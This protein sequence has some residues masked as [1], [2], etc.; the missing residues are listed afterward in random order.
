MANEQ[1][2]PPTRKEFARLRQRIADLEERLDEVESSSS[3]KTG[4]SGPG[5]HRDN[6]V[7]EQL[8]EGK[9]YRLNQVARLYREHTDVRN[10][11]TAKE[12]AKTLVEGRTFAIVGTDN[13]RFR[14]G[15]RP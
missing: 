3:T 13:F 11:K 5:D 6:A 14:G 10:R 8:V 9:Q 15:G 2:Y 4:G 1:E 12:R 7:I